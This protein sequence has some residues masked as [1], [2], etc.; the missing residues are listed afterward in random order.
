MSSNNTTLNENT[1]KKF[2]CFLLVEYSIPKYPNV[3]ITHVVT[4]VF[5]F[6]ANF[7]NSKFVTY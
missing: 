6:E 5:A 2:V 1:S 3:P 7:A 4:C